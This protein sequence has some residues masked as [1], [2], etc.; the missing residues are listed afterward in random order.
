MDEAIQLLK[1]IRDLLQRAENRA[2]YPHLFPLIPAPQPWNPWP[3]SQPWCDGTG[4]P[5]PG[6]TTIISK[7]SS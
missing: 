4:S 2:M 7:V 1:D 3:F 6:Q 5:P